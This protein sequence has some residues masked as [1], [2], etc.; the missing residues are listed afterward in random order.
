[1]LLVKENNMEYSLLHCLK[2]K[3]KIKSI[4]LPKFFKDPATAGILQQLKKDSRIDR[5]LNDHLIEET[6]DYSKHKCH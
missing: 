4:A 5:N 3:L 1:M 6:V 2:W